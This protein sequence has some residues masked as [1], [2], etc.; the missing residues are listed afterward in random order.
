MNNDREDDNGVFARFAGWLVVVGKGKPAMILAVALS[1][2]AIFAVPPYVIL[3]KVEGDSAVILVAGYFLLL[4]L[5]VP[6]FLML[7]EG[8]I[9]G[10]QG[11]E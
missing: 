3:T 5:I 7:C 6:M 9:H 8:I 4:L 1:V 2:V 11:N 10:S